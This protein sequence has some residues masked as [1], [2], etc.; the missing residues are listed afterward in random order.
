MS[1][2][3]FRSRF[4]KKSILIVIHWI[5]NVNN[6]LYASIINISG[7][8]RIRTHDSWSQD[9]QIVSCCALIDSGMRPYGNIKEYYG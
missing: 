9:A 4:L 3:T 1:G 7:E 8:A 5:E 6:Q 2:N